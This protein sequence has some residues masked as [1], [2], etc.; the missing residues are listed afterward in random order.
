MIAYSESEI[1]V[2][3]HLPANDQVSMFHVWELHA[4]WGWWPLIMMNV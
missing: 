1:L 3:S 2:K 4:M